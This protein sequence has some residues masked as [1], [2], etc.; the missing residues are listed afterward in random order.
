MISAVCAISAARSNIGTDSPKKTICGRSSDPSGAVA[1]SRCSHPSIGTI[2]PESR[3]E[4][5]RVR[6]AVQMRHPRRS[7]AL[8]EVID[9]LRQHLDLESRSRLRDG[10]MPGVRLGG[11]HLATAFVVK[12]DHGG[13]VVRQGF[14]RADILDAVVGPQAVRIAERGKAAVGAHPGARKNDYSFHKLKL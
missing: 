4:R 13:A 12:F 9:I 14:G 1:S 10:P 11:E 5:R 3:D 7:G 2:S 8:V 6:L